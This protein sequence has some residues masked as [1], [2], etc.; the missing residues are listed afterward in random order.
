MYTICKMQPPQD[1][2]TAITRCCRQRMP[3]ISACLRPRREWMWS[4]A[5]PGRIHSP[6]AW[7][8]WLICFD[9][10]LNFLAYSFW[11]MVSSLSMALTQMHIWWI[12]SLSPG[13]HQ[14]VHHETRGSVAV[15][16]VRPRNL[17]LLPSPW[18]HCRAWHCLVTNPAAML[19]SG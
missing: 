6:S 18:R 3:R 12:L 11:T 13:M 4:L 16:F 2:V 5:S 8:S 17:F 19:G 10:F 14:I 15:D 9:I 7:K 1:A